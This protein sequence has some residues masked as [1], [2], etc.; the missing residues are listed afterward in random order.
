LRTISFHDDATPLAELHYYAT[1]PQS[2]YGDGRVTYDVPGIARERLEKQSG[3]FQIYFNGCGGNIGM[4]KYNDGTPAAREALSGRLFDAMARSAAEIKRQPVAR[5]SWKTTS[6]EFPLR[7]DAE[8]SAERVRQVMHQAG[9]G[10]LKAAMLQGW[11][12]RVQAGRPV[13]LSCLT[14]GN[15]RIAHLPGEPFVEFQLAAQQLRPD[16]VVAVAGY[17]DCGMW[18][19]GPDSI[20]SDRGGY[21]QTWSFTGPCEQR[22][23]TAL[24][25]LLT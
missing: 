9:A 3:V 1:H 2:F 5:I 6:V 22:I 20:Y 15:V 14:I 23:R 18:Y 11:I 16:L 4:G 19:F 25:E 24:A 7:A 21:E 17:G 10:R 13:E 12:G 8:F